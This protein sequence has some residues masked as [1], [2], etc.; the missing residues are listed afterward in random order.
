[1]QL[2][3]EHTLLW[4]MVNEFTSGKHEETPRQSWSRRRKAAYFKHPQEGGPA[5]NATNE[6]ARTWLEPTLKARLGR[7]PHEPMSSRQPEMSAAA[8]SWTSGAQAC[9]GCSAWLCVLLV[10]QLDNR[11]TLRAEA[12]GRSVVKAASY[13]AQAGLQVTL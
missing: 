6:P 1:M 4:E 9:L 13:V 12:F 10:E 5:K 11:S 3:E 7:G 8:L 2:S